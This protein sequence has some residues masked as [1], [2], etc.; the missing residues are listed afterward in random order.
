MHRVMRKLKQ[1][2]LLSLFVAG[3]TAAAPDAP[4]ESA[5]AID[6][7][8]IGRPREAVV[9]AETHRTVDPI[10]EAPPASEVFI[11]GAVGGYDSTGL[12]LL[13]NGSVALW[14]NGSGGFKFRTPMSAGATYDVTI[15]QQP[16]DGSRCRIYN[17]IG[18]ADDSVLD[19][20]V[21]CDAP[22]QHAC[23]GPQAQ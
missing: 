1:V 22:G 16:S 21:T 7:D 5:A 14:I 3:C 9:A 15:R 23:D 6:I 18:I 10:E 11:G 17:G 4:S 2:A 13:N 20:I 19:V 8:P 12:I